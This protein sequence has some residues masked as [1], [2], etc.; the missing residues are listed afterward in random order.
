M[1]SSF[2]SHRDSFCAEMQCRNC[3]LVASTS[4]IRS[5]SSLRVWRWSPRQRERVSLSRCLPSASRNAWPRFGVVR[6]ESCPFGFQAAAILELLFLLGVFVCHDSTLHLG[7]ILLS[8]PGLAGYAQNN[9]ENKSTLLK[10]AGFCAVFLP[11]LESLFQFCGSCGLWGSANLGGSLG[12]GS[13]A[14]AWQLH[15]IVLLS[16]CAAGRTARWSGTSHRPSPMA[17]AS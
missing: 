13:C 17:M 8:L 14:E 1:C 2:L 12:F 6:R 3:S 10:V 16:S 15:H 5:R 9:E 4:A 7:V 11:G